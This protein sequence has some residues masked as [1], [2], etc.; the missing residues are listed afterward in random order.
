MAFYSQISLNF[1]SIDVFQ[2]LE[3]PEHCLNSKFS[4]FDRFDG[5]DKHHEINLRLNIQ[6]LFFGEFLSLFP[7]NLI[8]FRNL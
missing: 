8:L 3:R 2:H 6:N 1:L 5:G 4:F 7:V